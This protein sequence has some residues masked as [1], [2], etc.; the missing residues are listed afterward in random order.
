MK[1]K[2]S[3][4]IILLILNFGFFDLLCAQEFTFQVPE[5]EVIDNGNIFKGTKRGE[6]I[7]DDQIK[8]IS[9]NFE[10]QSSLK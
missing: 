7:T 2:I 5:I 8:L 10:Y 1:N 6:V 4:I 9:N 3:K